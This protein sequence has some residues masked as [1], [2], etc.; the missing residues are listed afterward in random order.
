MVGTNVTF[1]PMILLGYGGMS[2]RYASYSLPVG[3]TKCFALLHQ[4]ATIGV[5]LL[6]VGQLIFV[7]NLV[8][9]WLDGKRVDSDDPWD[10]KRD[11]Q[12]TREWE[13]FA[14]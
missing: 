14:T 11:G 9:S 1:F 12:Y 4:I 5:V 8:S 3:P 6:V 10:L 7:W 2:R 13:Q